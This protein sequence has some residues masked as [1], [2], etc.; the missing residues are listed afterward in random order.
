MPC[1]EMYNFRRNESGQIAILMVMVLPVIFLMFALALDAGIWYLDHRIAQN[2][3]DASVLAAVQQLPASNTGQATVTAKKWLVKNGSG[4]E[5][6]C[7]PDEDGPFPQY[8]DRYPATPDGLMDTV[9]V[10]VRRQS[11]S[12]FAGL[13]GLDFIYISAVAGATAVGGNGTY[14]IFANHSC[15]NTDPNLDFPGSNITVT[16]AM[17]SNCNLSMG[18]S[19]NVFDGNATYVG[20]NPISGGGNTCNE[21]ICNPVQTG[22]LPMPINYTFDDVRSDCTY[23]NVTDLASGPQY[24]VDFSIKE[25]LNPGVYCNEFGKI[26]LS[27]V[28]VSGNITLAADEVNVSGSS[29][30]LTG[31]WNDMLVMAFSDSGSAI[32]ASGSGGSWDGAMYAPNGQAKIAGSDGL[33]VGGTIIADQVVLS[34]SDITIV[35]NAIGATTIP[36]TYLIE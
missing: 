9:R 21:G 31:Y 12:I 14:S 13:A 36:Q 2:Q 35:G 24:W 16:G 17:H 28:N 25:S 8:S 4:P 27:G 10:C 33:S 7:K 29:F 30:N 1:K 20:E 18:G 15:P 3:V 5:D 26:V 22:P 23:T 34:G 11:P 32:D 19:D 6:L